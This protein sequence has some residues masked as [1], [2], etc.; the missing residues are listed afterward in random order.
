MIEILLLILLGRKN[1]KT[2]SLKGRKGL[3][4]FLLTLL[5][6]IGSEFIGALIGNLATNGNP[7]GTYGIALLFALI[8]GMASYFIAKNCKPGNSLGLRFTRLAGAQPLEMPSI[9][10]ISPQIN[11]AGI[12]AKYTVYLN[13]NPV[14]DVMNCQRIQSST[15]SASNIMVVVD[16]FGAEL[17]PMCFETPPGG[18]CL[19]TFNVKGIMPDQSTGINIV[20]CGDISDLQHIPMAGTAVSDFSCHNLPGNVPPF[21]SVLPVHQPGAGQEFLGNT[22]L[23]VWLAGFA[24]LL[25]LVLGFGFLFSHNVNFTLLSIIFGLTVITYCSVVYSMLLKSVVYY[26]ISISIVVLELIITLI[27]HY[28]IFRAVSGHAPFSQYLNS[29]SVGFTVISFVSTCLLVLLVPFLVS[30]IY[31]RTLQQRIRLSGC[32]IS[33]IWI[34]SGIFSSVLLSSAPFSFSNLARLIIE[35]ISI[36]II[37][38]LIYFACLLKIKTFQTGIGSKIWFIICIVFSAFQILG[39]CLNPMFNTK[40]LIFYPI[41]AII[42]FIMMLMSRRIGFYMLLSTVILHIPV[43]YEFTHAVLGLST[44]LSILLSISVLINP[45]ITWLIIRGN[46]TRQPSSPYV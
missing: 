11:L 9:L 14:G 7:I 25:K 2:A 6:W 10:T 41:I 12:A 19:I 17:K 40:F 13:G 36:F 31:N 44:P 4:F 34:I 3:N 45:L 24:L 32:I 21:D 35:A 20:S 46:W 22:A 18:N 27:I 43:V 26:Y 33:I 15:N 37:L 42:A 39:T 16:P 8:G 1:S 30:K 38:N 28:L 5:L 29:F 23:P